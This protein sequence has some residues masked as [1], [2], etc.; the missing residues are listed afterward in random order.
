MKN[1]ILSIISFGILALT[2]S[3]FAGE[4][5]LYKWTD[6]K[7]EVHYTERAPKGG[8]EYKRIRTY[9]DAANA[10]PVPVPKNPSAADSQAEKKKDSYGTWR[11]ENCKIATQNLDILENAGRIGVDDG[12]GGKRLMTDEEKAQKVAHMKKEQAKYCDKSADD[13]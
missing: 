2:F 10:A 4:K 7:G 3:A 1:V 8:I 6:E 5:I 11:D 9:V 13:S 12:Q